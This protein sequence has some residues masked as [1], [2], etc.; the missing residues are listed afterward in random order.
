MVRKTIVKICG[1]RNIKDLRTVEKYADFTGVVVKSNSRRCISLEEAGKIIKSSEI[2]VF[3]VS[4]ENTFEGW[5]E[6]IER[7]QAEFIQIHSE[8]HPVVVEK[9]RREFDVYIMMAFEIPKF[10]EDPWRDAE[11]ISERIDEYELDLVLLDT[12]KG[13]GEIHDHRVSRILARH[14]KAL[15]AGGLTPENVSEILKFVNPLGVD[16]SSGVERDGR[17]DPELVRRFSEEVSRFDSPL[18]TSS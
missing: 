7:T 1:V 5:R 12:G 4:T 3:V 16:V 6:I 2:P 18:E 15:I 13:S 17:K 9:L 10:S 14:Y 11:V 8:I